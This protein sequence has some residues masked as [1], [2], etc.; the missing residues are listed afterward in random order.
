VPGPLKQALLLLVSELYE[1]REA[2]GDR[3]RVE[4]P[5]AVSALVAPYRVWSF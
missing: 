1:N 3:P 2:A 4:L 5:F